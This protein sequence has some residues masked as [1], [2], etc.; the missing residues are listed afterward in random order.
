MIPEGL[1]QRL[2]TELADRREKSLLR[3]LCVWENSPGWINLADNDYLDLSHDPTVVAAAQEAASRHGCSSSASPLIS[4]YQV[5][6]YDLETELCRW[7]GFPSGLV[8]NSGYAANQAVLSRLPRREDIVFADR[9]IHNSM[10]S[11]ILHS[12]ARLIRYRHNDIAH[13]RQLLERHASTNRIS[14]V[15]T[16]SVFSMDGDAPDLPDIA[17]LKKDFS[18]CLVVDEAHATGWHGT[19]GAG[20]ASETG[21]LASVDLLVGTLGKG[22]GSQGAY[23]L[24]HNQLLREHLLNHANEFI[25][26]TYLSPIAAAAAKAAIGRV[27]ELSMHQREWRQTSQEFRNLLRSDGWNVPAGDSPIVP[28]LLG[29]SEAALSLGTFL[30]EQQILAGTVRPPTVPAGS[31]RLRLSLKRSFTME[32]ARHI[33]DL[34]ARW[35]SRKS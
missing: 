33:V 13:L 2:T 35:R 32:T 21:T 34:L 18:F 6:H 10:I 22:L 3:K 7:H 30:R 1:Q 15:V 27:R 5:P 19:D 16:E 9:L 28:I 26:S 14:F 24:F 11:G 17:S 20:F 12:G 25:Y 23:T 4:G 8:W 29:E 31:S